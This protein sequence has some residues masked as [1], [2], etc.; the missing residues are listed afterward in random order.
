MTLI[1]YKIIDKDLGIR[2]LELKGINKAVPGLITNIFKVALAKEYDDKCDWEMM[3]G[4][5]VE[6]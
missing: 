5:L 3:L 4:M 2:G 6:N 1:I